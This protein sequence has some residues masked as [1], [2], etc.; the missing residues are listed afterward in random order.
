MDPSSKIYLTD[1]S[2]DSLV[3]KWLRDSI[4]R[5]E[6]GKKRRSVKSNK[7]QQGAEKTGL[8]FGTYTE[9]EATTSA[10]ATRLQTL[11]SHQSEHVAT[12]YDS[13]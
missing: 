10:N 13:D 8:E 3:A 6:D 1:D 9:G 2:L 7:A 4:G 12:D 5:G 11:I